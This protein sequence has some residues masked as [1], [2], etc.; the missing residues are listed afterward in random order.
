LLLEVSGTTQQAMCSLIVLPV[1][2]RKSYQE[3]CD[4][5][6]DLHILDNSARLPISDVEDENLPTVDAV[7]AS[8]KSRRSESLVSSPKEPS[9]PSTSSSPSSTQ[10]VAATQATPLE[11]GGSESLEELDEEA[12]QQGAYNEETGEIN[13]DC[14]CLGGMAH[15]P[16]GPEFRDAFSCF[17]HS[18]DEPK[19]IDC[20]DK[21]K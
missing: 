13:W 12:D 2:P 14:P 17:I 16:C 1:R 5:T 21:F 7:A 4:R 15:G 18:K 9:L 19:G 3:L 11:A 10:A 20:I 8:R 6:S